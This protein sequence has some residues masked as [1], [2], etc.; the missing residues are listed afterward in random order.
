ML[1]LLF[2]LVLVVIAYE[3][4]MGISYQSCLRNMLIDSEGLAIVKKWYG[5]VIVEKSDS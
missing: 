4:W 3:W 2:L 1:K 5:Y